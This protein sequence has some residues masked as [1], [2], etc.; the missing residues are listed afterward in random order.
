MVRLASV[1]GKPRMPP[2]KP[3]PRRFAERCG[4]HAWRSTLPV[5]TIGV[6]A[7][8]L[9]LPVCEP[10]S[11]NGAFAFPIRRIRSGEKGRTGRDTDS[12]S[13]PSRGLFRRTEAS[14]RAPSSET[15]FGRGG[16]RRPELRKRGAG[17]GGRTLTPGQ[18]RWI[19]S[20]VR[21]P[22]PPLQLDPTR[23][24][25][26]RLSTGLAL[27]PSAWIR[28]NVPRIGGPAAPSERP[29]SSL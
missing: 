16:C 13:R 14:P 19:L 25:T 27:V 28:M 1:P 4:E 7:M 2:A 6:D 24:E 23:N 9:D 20:P 18:G 5:P 26:C 17:G 22:I 3:E 11:S 15:D 8:P 29:C 10:K 21:L 12:C